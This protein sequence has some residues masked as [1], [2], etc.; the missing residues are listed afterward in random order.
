MANGKPDV[1]NCAD[2]FLPTWA[3]PTSDQPQGLTLTYATP[4][5]PSQVNIFLVGNPQEIL[6]I[7][8]VN[9][10]TKLGKLIYDREQPGVSLPG[11]EKCPATFSIPASTEFEVDTVIIH[12][13]ASQTP[14]QIDAVELVGE[15]RGY[16]ELP[17]F[18]RAPLPGAPISLAAGQNGLVYIVTDPDGYANYADPARDEL[19]AYDVEGNQL[20]KISIPA[21]SDLK[22][23][24]A[25]PF[26]NLVI[27]DGISDKFVI[28]SPEG[29]QLTTGGEDPFSQAV[30]SPQDGNLYLLMSSIIFVYTTD[31]AELVREMWLDDLHSYTGLAFDP[32]GAL[33][34]IR[35]AD[36]DPTWMQLSPSTG[37]EMNAMPLKSSSIVDNV[38]RDLA[39]D[40]NGNFYILFGL[41]TSDIAVHMLDPNGYFLRRFGKLDYDTEPTP[42]GSFFEPRTI[43]VSPDGR[44][45]FIADGREGDYHLTAFLLEPEQ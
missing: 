13:A 45:I 25:D 43:A 9:S 17:V 30:V 10:L 24:A 26:G 23:V 31:T 20:K 6:R 7:E 29:K 14:L 16:I 32:L 40:A 33:Y 28:L 22:D 35:D 15:L 4:L 19:Y 2:P 27:I 41:N 12:T 34:T 5:L 39:V 11:G 42:E 44:F 18:W 3:P 38:A 1:T 21:G 37:N 8:V 36:W